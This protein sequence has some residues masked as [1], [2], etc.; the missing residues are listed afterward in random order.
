MVLG[1]LAIMVLMAITFA[2]TTR[3]SRLA[4]RNYADSVKARQLTHTAMARLLYD[5]NFALTNGSLSVFPPTNTFYSVGNGLTTNEQEN[6][7]SGQVP[8]FFPSNINLQNEK[9]KVAWTNIYNIDD[10]LVGR[11]TYFVADV[12]GTIDANYIVTSNRNL[13]VSGHELQSGNFM[14]DISSLSNF[15]DERTNDWIRFETLTELRQA[16]EGI[17]GGGLNSLQVYSRYPSGQWFDSGKLTNSYDLSGT[18]FSSNDVI[19]VINE[20]NDGINPPDRI[21]PNVFTYTLKDYIDLD[22]TPDRY[23]PSSEAVPM[24]NEVELRQSTFHDGSNATHE[25]TVSVELWYPFTTSATNTFSSQPDLNVTIRG[26]GSIPILSFQPPAN[27]SQ[28]VASSWTYNQYGGAVFPVQSRTS[29]A[30]IIPTVSSIS[31]DIDLVSNGQVY[32]RVTNLTFDTSGNTFGTPANEETYTK[33]I[34]DPRINYD[35]GEWQD[36]SSSSL[37][38]INTNITMT[39]SNPGKDGSTAMYASDAGQL[40]SIGELGFL[41]FKE[42]APWETISFFRPVHGKLLDYFTLHSNTTRRGLVNLNTQDEEALATAF[43][44]WPIRATPD[45]P[46]GTT[47]YV[48]EN[49]AQD[50]ASLI[51]D[52]GPYINL[53]DI[54]NVTRSAFYSDLTGAISVMDADNLLRESIDL[55]GIRQNLF[56]CVLLVQ[57]VRETDAGLAVLAEEKAA[58]L[59]W[60]DPFSDETGHP[61]VVRHLLR[62]ID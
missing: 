15:M 21:D 46:M 42:G 35:L 1:L 16:D 54:T 31:L 19:D 7:I 44:Q 18:S 56:A 10:E 22:H 32:D 40:R 55:F 52:A 30:L 11:F 12:S 2:V 6:F 34:D 38:T 47:N 58:V 28:P 62:L 13:G 39:F 17:S 24:I 29:P 59:L 49:S 26:Q 41:H 5:L 43:Y 51:I 27:V 14:S 23:G 3:T 53:S 48:D 8:A 9:S 50:L 33:A 60:R 37:G 57:A 4:S 45:E 61:Y 36:A 25:V 20:L